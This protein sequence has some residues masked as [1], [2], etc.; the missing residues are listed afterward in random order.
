[1]ALSEYGVFVGT[2]IDNL[3]SSEAKQRN[4]GGSPHY[5]I[6]V[7]NGNVKYRLAVNVKSDQKPSDLQ[8]Y[9]DDNYQHPILQEFKTLNDGFTKLK[10]K[11]NTAALDFI[12][13]NLFDMRDLRIVPA[14]DS[15]SQNDLND[16]FDVH[17]EQA[18]NTT[19]ALIYAFG[20][21]W[22]P[23]PHTPDDYFDFLPGNGIHDIH[24]NQGSK[25]RHAHDNGIYQDGGLF[26]YYP[27]EDRW[28]AMFLKFQSQFIDTGDILQEDAAVKIIAA[29]VNPKGDDVT[30]ETVYLLNTTDHDIDISNWKIADKQKK[31]EV[32]SNTILTAGNLVQIHLSGKG[33]QLSNDGGIIT[34]VSSRGV[35]IDGVSYTKKQT[36]KKGY[37]IPF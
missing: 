22:G 18:M 35:K 28:V 15:S 23:E 14:V 3:D 6:L 21:R 37:V 26:I 8:F 13:G 19:G 27:D 11:A 30:K 7:Q 20:S 4:P 25:G 1:M 24:M 16:I 33:A 17:I 36:E 12:R 2:V 9:L 34:L 5:E 29:L 31:E 32:I 10:S